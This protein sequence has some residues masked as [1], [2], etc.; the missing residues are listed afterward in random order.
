MCFLLQ[1]WPQHGALLQVHC[2]QEG[3][4]PSAKDAANAADDSESD[5]EPTPVSHYVSDAALLSSQSDYLTHWNADTGATSSMTPHRHYFHTYQP[6]RRPI[7]MANGEVVYSEGIGSVVFVPV[8]SG[9]PCRPVEF[10]DVLHVPSLSNNLLSV[11]HL[12]C[13]RSVTV[14]IENRTMTFSKHNQVLFEAVINEHNTAHLLGETVQESAAMLSAL[15]TLLSDWLLWH[16]RFAHH[17]IRNLKAMVSKELVHGISVER[18]ANSHQ[19]PICEPCMAGKMAAHPFHS[20]LTR[21][22]HPLELVHSDLHH[23]KSPTHDGYKYWITFIDDCTRFPV[24][25]LLKRKAQA[26]EAFQRYKAFAENRT[27]HKIKALQDDK[28][29]EYMSNAFHEF[30][31]SAGIQRRHSTRNRPQQNGVGER[32]NRT[33]D[34]HCTAMLYQANLPAS[35]MGECVLAYVHTWSMIPSSL[36]PKSTPYFDWY[37]SKPDASRVRTFG[38]LAYVHV[39][40]DKRTGIGSHME[41]CIFVGYPPGYKAWE[42]YN[43]ITRR[44]IICERAEFDDRHCPGLSMKSLPAGSPPVPDTQ[45]VKHLQ[46][47]GVIDQ[48]GESSDQQDIPAAPRFNTHPRNPAPGEFNAPT[49]PALPAREQDDLPPSRSLQSSVPAV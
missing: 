30:C 42:F 49:P 29:G 10:F 24:V 13:H 20:T 9:S 44:F 38:C 33:L 15:S 6:H 7:R 36:S 40:K 11:L 16:M 26:L 12:V 43:P 25:I 35:F 27:Q 22:Q 32:A 39:Q 45:S 3:G 41:K 28:G 4:Q 18:N 34:E 17:S 8:I 5:T 14:N 47:E 2:C 23:L 46:S 37:A 1:A 19:A 31:S 48:P 21:A